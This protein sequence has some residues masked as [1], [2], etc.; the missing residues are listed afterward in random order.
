MAKEHH[1]T[2]TFETGLELSA[3][4]FSV[5]ESLSR[6]FSVRVMANSA[7]ADLDLESVIGKA[8]S[9]QI[10]TGVVH[11]T[12]PKRRW[13]GVC[14]RIEQV[15][16]V[17]VATG[18]AT[19]LVHVVPTLW[20][21]TQRVETRIFQNMTLP[22]VVERVL[23]EWH[24]DF[25]DEL[26]RE[27]YRKHDYV[28][29][30]GETDYD[31]ICRLMEWEGITHYFRMPPDF[32]PAGEKGGWLPTPA[33]RKKWKDS[34]TADK[35]KATRKA[36]YERRAS[37]GWTTVDP[38]AEDAAKAQEVKKKSDAV[39]M[40]ALA[41]TIEKNTPRPFPIDYA[42]RPN[43]QAEQ[44]YVTRVRLQHEIRPGRFTLRDHDFRR[45]QD[46]R[47]FGNEEKATAGRPPEDFYESY[48]YEP[49]GFLLEKSKTAAKDGDTPIADS[50]VAYRH[51]IEEGKALANRRLVAERTDKRQVSF[52]T[53]C[54]DVGPGVV[55]QIDRHPRE[56]IANK[57]LLV[58]E[59]TLEGL[60]NEEWTFSARAVF[61]DV[62]HAPRQRTPKPRIHGVQSAVVTGP[63]DQEIHTDELGRVKVQFHWDR[64]GEYDDKSSC[65]V[66]VSQ[67]WA[68]TGFGTMMIPRIGHE[69][70]IGFLEGD[71]DNP[72]IV[73]RVYNNIARVPYPLPKH[74]T[75][76]TWKS[77]S[78]PNA[79]GFNELM[80]EDLKDSELVYLQAERHVQ[81]LVK[82]FETDR[83]GQNHMTIVGEN[84]S[85]V[86]GKLEATMIGERWLLRSIEPPKPEDLKILPQ[87][88][89]QI[90]PL[91]T[92]IDM[93]KGQ[94]VFTTG[95]AT[96][97]FVDDSI[98]FKADGSITVMAKG[99]DI[100][101]EAALVD[102][103]D[104]TPAAPPE[105]KPFELD[106][107]GVFHDD[108]AE[109]KI[110]LEKKNQRDKAKVREVKPPDAPPEAEQK[111]CVLL[112]SLVHCQHPNALR[113]P[114][115]DEEDPDYH[116]LQV[117]ADASIGKEPPGKDDTRVKTDWGFVKKGIDTITCKS[118]LKGGCGEHVAWT[119][120]T[121]TKSETQKP[122]L[123]TSFEVEGW[124]HNP[125]ASAFKFSSADLVSGKGPI[126]WKIKGDLAGVDKNV[127]LYEKHGSQWDS[128]ENVT[129]RKEDALAKDKADR[130][131]DPAA[132]AAKNKE[133][134][135]SFTTDGVSWVPNASPREY[136]V[137]ARAC[138]GSHSYRIQCYPADKLSLT[139][140]ANLAAAG[141]ASQWGWMRGLDVLLTKYLGKYVSVALS[142]KVSLTGSAYW[143]EYEKDHR[144]YYRY[145]F[146]LAAAPLF[147]ATLK[148]NVPIGSL[149]ADLVFPGSGAILRVLSAVIDIGSLEL[150]LAGSIGG[151]L[152]F[153]RLS[154]DTWKPEVT[155]QIDG[156]ISFTA[157][158]SA[159]FL[160]KWVLSGSCSGSSK[161][162]LT[163][164]PDKNAS[165]LEPFQLVLEWK[166]EPLTVTAEGTFLFVKKGPA[167][168]ALWEPITKPG[169]TVPLFP[170][171]SLPEWLGGAY[172]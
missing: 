132:F 171:Q 139:V 17:S 127:D 67:D 146:K 43:A 86:I 20:L 89:P 115:A 117:V 87:Q 59:S 149:I 15:S 2:L 23:N 151:S 70:L 60:I 30:Y 103:N 157:T 101:I 112:A 105:V 108:A 45:P 49:G 19:Y 135:F 120:V 119:I 154:P 104:K 6:W 126:D 129:K 66:R 136:S 7:D 106:P 9:F 169:G 56:D 100:I 163:G 47:L 76:S 78:S 144:A 64:D 54:I 92:A 74:D 159:F 81:K 61:T 83:V 128:Q 85:S 131:A 125:R 39:L 63:K 10:D 153:K 21:L 36:R 16:A 82:K 116:V 28:V 93:T 69:V 57:K 147:G 55:I 99:D 12:A 156:T 25:I 37:Q 58:V 71:P 77:D 32:K 62:P 109:K 5:H 138:T 90:K 98:C 164:K 137:T 133:R 160:A 170:A 94:V 140:D 4:R 96:V 148:V 73:G 3:M 80:F 72:I 123:D 35:T 48:R 65:W 51:D 118:R 46:F 33:N 31:F 44:E 102:V 111:I 110:E 141:G 24:I 121:P 68:G 95:K 75:R 165:L 113:Q 42:A 14:E 53:N 38:D 167:S 27:E 134:I 50:P 13:V 11:V 26:K 40:L 22:E 162:T 172:Q 152:S 168:A 166:W 79:D 158:L 88:K 124:L 161:L 18:Q 97:A 155:G 142:S 29:Q 34:E 150:A 8:V 84:R 145:D 114:C 41:D 107:P 143:A 130:A 52:V 91:E 1:L 122:K